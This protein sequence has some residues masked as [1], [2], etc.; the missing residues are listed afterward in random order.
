MEYLLGMACLAI[1][2][3]VG[4]VLLLIKIVQYPIESMGICFILALILLGAT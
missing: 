4:G 3:C 1:A 2:V